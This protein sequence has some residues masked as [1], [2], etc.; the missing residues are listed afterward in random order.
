MKVLKIVIRDLKNFI[1]QKKYIFSILIIGLIVA[2]YSLSFFTAQSLHIVDLVNT[3]FGYSTKYYIGGRK[4]KI[5]NQKFENL[6]AWLDQ[7]NLNKSKLNIYSEMIE[8]Q[9]ENHNETCVIVGSNS[10]KSNRSDFV[11]K[12]ITEEDLNNK[13][14]YILVEYYSEFVEDDPFLL[15]KNI[16]IGNKSYIVKAIDKI[17]YNKNIYFDCNTKGY[18]KDDYESH[19]SMV[20]IPYTTFLKNEYD[21]FS[22]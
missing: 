7:N 2:S 8:I 16:N 17:D 14:N 18:Y 12:E 15:N 9:G 5:D 13:S 11:G 4:E 22:I 3:Y 20:C 21:I 6:I 19:L 1:C 10:T